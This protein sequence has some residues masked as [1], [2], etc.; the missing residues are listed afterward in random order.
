VTAEHDPD[1]QALFD[2]LVGAARAR[3]DGTSLGLVRAAAGSR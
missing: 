2:A 3:R 1:Q